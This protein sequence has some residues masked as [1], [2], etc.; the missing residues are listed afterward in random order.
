MK[1]QNGAVL[2]IVLWVLAMLT[3]IGMGMS[4]RSGLD[5]R[6]ASA[7]TGKTQSLALAQAAIQRVGYE[8]ARDN[9][10]YDAWTDPWSNNKDL[11]DRYRMQTGSYTVAHKIP[12]SEQTLYG[13]GDEQSR[14]NANTASKEM[15]ERLLRAED[16]SP[17][18]AEAILDWI[19]ADSNAR[20]HGAEAYDYALGD[21]PYRPR[22]GKM[23][24]PEELLLVKG[25]TPSLFAK[26]APHLTVVGDGRVNINTAGERVLS[27]IGL[28]AD[29]VDKIARYRKGVDGKE[30][31][32]DDG[33][34]R[35]LTRVADSLQT[36][37]SVSNTDRFA[38]VNL[39]GLLTVQSRFFRIQ[40]QGDTP[41][42]TGT[43]VTALLERPATGMGTPAKL[44]SWRE[45]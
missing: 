15:W 32:E 29:L 21:N 40:A 9:A 39:T 42:G 36:T 19:D 30:G 38:L 41:S 27:A 44:L 31:T 12:G 24:M 18:L 2:V 13:A 20:F 14:L 26:L 1:N 43:R 34:F 3:A 25:V 28:P 22:N 45:D 17:D 8:L 33:V 10:S 11:F 4:Y 23:L 7:V 16:E 35:D 37:E 5:I 6:R